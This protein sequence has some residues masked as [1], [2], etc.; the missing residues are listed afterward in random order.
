LVFRKL[1]PAPAER[2]VDE[3]DLDDKELQV[4]ERVNS[5]RYARRE[6]IRLARGVDD[7]QR[8]VGWDAKFW[9]GF[10][11]KKESQV[12]DDPREDELGMWIPIVEN[13][14]LEDGKE[15]VPSWEERLDDVSLKRS[16]HP[17]CSRRLLTLSSTVNLVCRAV[18]R[19][20]RIH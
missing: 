5:R 2:S 7:Q 4:E 16:R 18:P 1:V 20:C 14:P 9:V 19:I 10:S 15:E 3:E 17:S 13:H 8:D 12:E 11:G 6:E